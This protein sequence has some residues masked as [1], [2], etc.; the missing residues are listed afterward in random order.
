MCKLFIKFNLN[1]PGLNC[2]STVNNN[3]SQLACSY[4]YIDI[5]NGVME[6]GE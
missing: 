1:I 3:F 6:T 2:L 5:L 4:I